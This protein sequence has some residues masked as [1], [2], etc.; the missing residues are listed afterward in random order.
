MVTA[1][2]SMHFSEGF[3]IRG[4]TA[5]TQHHDQNETCTAQGLI[6]LTLPDHRPSLEEVRTGSQAGLEPEGRS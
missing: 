2:T 4:S 3:L 6:W 1:L 5:A